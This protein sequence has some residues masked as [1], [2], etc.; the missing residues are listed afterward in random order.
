MKKCADKVIVNDWQKFHPS[1]ENRQRQ[2]KAEDQP[3]CL[4]SVHLG[5]ALKRKWQLTL[6]ILPELRYGN[7]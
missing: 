6:N 7:Q 1:I 4:K 2:E 5:R 3:S